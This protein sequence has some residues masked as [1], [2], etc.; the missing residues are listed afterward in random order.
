MFYIKEKLGK[1]QHLFFNVWMITYLFKAKTKN[2][3]I[4]MFYWFPVF[5][6][7]ECSFLYN[8]WMLVVKNPF[9]PN[10]MWFSPKRKYTYNSNLIS[11]IPD[12]KQFIDVLFFSNKD[13]TYINKY[14][15]ASYDTTRRELIYGTC[16]HIL[17]KCCWVI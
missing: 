9:V 13:N 10:S 12:V 1:T 7:I 17:Y 16:T 2:I 3:C 8:K 4:I 6:L 15:E 5:S 14:R 11:L